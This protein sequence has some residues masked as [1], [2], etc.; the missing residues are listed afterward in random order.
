MTV[1]ALDVLSIELNLPRTAVTP[2]AQRQQI[3]QI[4][5]TV[6]IFSTQI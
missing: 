2:N 5:A 3:V 6:R 1:E 4:A